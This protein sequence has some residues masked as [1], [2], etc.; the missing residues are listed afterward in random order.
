[1]RVTG[2]TLLL[3][4]T[5]VQIAAARI[6]VTSLPGRSSTQL[7][8]YNSVDLTVVVEQRVLVFRKGLNRLEF[9]WVN[10]LIDPTSVEF[11]VRTHA[12]ALEVVDVS[13]PPRVANTLE[14]RIQSEFSGEALVEI[15]YFTSGVSWTADY[16]A[17]A[18]PREIEL[19]L[20]GNVRATN[21]SG[22]DYENAQIRL[23]VGTVRLVEE[24]VDLARRRNL[25]RERMPTSALIAGDEVARKDVKL[26]FGV[27]FDRME[28][29]AKQKAVVKENLSEYFLYTVEG[30]DT[31]PT[32]WSKRLPSFSASGVPVTSLYKFER[33][34]W[35]DSVMRFYQFTNSSDAHLG[36][37]P[38][39]DGTVFAFR[40]V[41]DDLL[42][43]FV[44]R[45]SVKYIPIDEVV[46]LELGRDLEVAIRPVLLNWTKGDIAFDN[47]GNVSGWTTKETWDIEVQNSKEI[48][49]VVDLRRRFAGDWSLET[50]DI[51]TA[52]DAQRVKFVL[53]LA[54]RQRQSI[55]YLVTTRHGT[56][57]RR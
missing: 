9:S 46:E 40:T 11:K 43:A 54:P 20:A 3:L 18:T 52:I 16:V 38:L 41:S 29:A 30:R 51:Y 34:V 44:G 48:P 12:D 10:T 32:G 24:V 15:R 50:R 33:E 36:N 4:T 49:V 53:P 22:E 57:A 23:V 28:V 45:T 26:A 6:N 8:I 31:I 5:A 13:F 27:A 47:D 7:T 35:G 1:M 56:N 42:S 25:E 17:Q 39:P 14:W 55:E 19:A 2:L 21:R 37:E